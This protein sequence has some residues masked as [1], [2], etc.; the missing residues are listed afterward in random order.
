MKSDLAVFLCGSY[1]YVLQSNSF[2][3]QFLAAFSQQF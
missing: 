2:K 1:V 3:L